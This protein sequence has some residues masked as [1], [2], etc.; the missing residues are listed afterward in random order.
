MRKA[1]YET[2]EIGKPVGVTL[3]CDDQRCD[4][5]CSALRVA[6]LGSPGNFSEFRTGS[7]PSLPVLQH[8]SGAACLP[9]ESR[10]FSFSQ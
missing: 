6:A 10:V 3:V 5:L 2:R 1:T 8:R 4:P 9:W 7:V